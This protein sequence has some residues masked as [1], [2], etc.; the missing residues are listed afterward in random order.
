M[1]YREVCKYWST[2]TRN[3]DF[4]K[5]YREF[6]KK[7]HLL[8][9]TTPAGIS[10]GTPATY[11]DVSERLSPCEFAFTTHVRGANGL[12]FIHNAYCTPT[13]D[14]HDMI[15][16]INPCTRKNY[17]LPPAMNG[18]THRIYHFGFCTTGN[19]EYY[20]VL[21]VEKT[22]DEKCAFN[23]FTLGSTPRSWT[24]ID[25]NK[26]ID[27]LPFD[28]STRSFAESNSSVCMDGVI[29]WNQRRRT[30][31][32]SNPMPHETHSQTRIVEFDTAETMIVAFDVEAET[33]SEVPPPRA[34]V[35][36][37]KIVEVCGCVALLYVIEDRWE[38][39][40][41]ILK[42]SRNHQWV[43]ETIFASFLMAGRGPRPFY[44]L[45]TGGKF[46]FLRGNDMMMYVYDME[47]K[48]L[49]QVSEVI[50]PE[51]MREIS[52]QLRLV[53]FYDD[54]IVTFKRN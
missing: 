13:S 39:E 28:M 41:W 54:T 29:Y 25:N 36:F 17:K 30:S 6:N 51:G 31:A 4:L 34:C 14:E 33:F 38:I 50:W 24:P 45:L 12:M 53:D 9:L 26:F 49:V 32:T 10:D 43:K 7:T 18:R 52:H 40:L 44:K 21:Q 22:P 2:L 46:M 42:D 15:Y 35:K 37:N 19:N 11:V 16:V 27:A 8:F 48:K 3:P 20:K 1:R 47:N 23:I 5:A